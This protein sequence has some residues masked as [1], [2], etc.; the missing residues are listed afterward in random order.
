MTSSPLAP[1]P[2]PQPGGRSGHSGVPSASGSSTPSAPNLVNGATVH[3]LLGPRRMRHPWEIPLVIVAGLVTFNAYL[4]WIAMVVLLIIPSTREGTLSA[5]EDM[6]IL[7]Q[8]LLI[9]PL[10]PLIIW[11]ARALLY[12][13][14][15]A[16]AA[17]MS[18]TQF[19]E[20]YRMVAEAAQQFGLRRVPDAYVTSGNGTINAFAAGHGFR[21][22]V[23]VYSDMF[24][25][26]GAVR[27][28]EAL[29]FVIA[30][31]VGHLA[32]GHVGYF[33]LALTNLASQVPILGKALSRAQEYTADNFGYAHC[34]QGSAGAMAVLSA[35]KYL[36]AEVN[37]H[38]LA[39]R[40]GHE[41]GLWLHIVQWQATH[42]ILTWRAHA[43]RDRSRP[44]AMFLRPGLISAHGS[45]FSEVLPA[46]SSFS[47]RYPT[48]EQALALLDQAAAVREPGSDQQFGRFPGADY[49]MR[50]SMREVQMAMP[51]LSHPLHPPVAAS[52][53]GPTG[54]TPPPQSPAA[55]QR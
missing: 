19:P 1:P 9:V 7:L 39:D 53:Q 51:V 54:Q 31:E 6:S 25:V 48:P 8:L 15:R 46:G 21:R 47:G 22:T 5:I 18:P 16:S 44:G 14:Q 37:V 55:P 2:T 38:E 36:N 42:P 10:L 45:W 17:R 30:H 41:K 20:G 50:P 28:P 40:A 34:P 33:R 3:G 32:A 24:E 35:G 27:D 12:A 29:R 23:V 49:A 52:G 4:A 13:Q 26:G 11:I 43:L